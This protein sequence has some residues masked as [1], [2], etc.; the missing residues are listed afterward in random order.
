M[1]LSREALQTAIKQRE[2]ACGFAFTSLG[3]CSDNKQALHSH[4]IQSCASPELSAATHVSAQ[5]R[6]ASEALSA[7][8]DPFFRLLSGLTAAL[9]K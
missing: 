4:F 7:H 9:K 8:G 1:V 3:L 6:R 5:I 2:F